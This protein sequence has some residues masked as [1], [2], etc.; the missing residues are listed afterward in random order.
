MLDWY[1]LVGT[2]RNVETEGSVGTCCYWEKSRIQG[3]GWYLL[4]PGEY[5]SLSWYLSVLEETLN[6]ESYIHGLVL[7]GTGRNIEYGKLHGLVL[8]G[9][10]RNVEYGGLGAK[11][12]Q[13]SRPHYHPGGSS[14]TNQGGVTRPG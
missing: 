8:V 5:G 11:F 6:M 1:L 10:G 14:T 4:V 13:K 7:V 12:R 3:L 2:G 9:T